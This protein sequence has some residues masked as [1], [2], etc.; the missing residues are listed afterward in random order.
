[1]TKML[2]VWMIFG[3]RLLSSFSV[4][5]LHSFLKCL[6]YIVKQTQTSLKNYNSGLALWSPRRN[7]F[8]DP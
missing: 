6:R 4:S 7:L 2:I 8:S 3:S 5:A 1:M